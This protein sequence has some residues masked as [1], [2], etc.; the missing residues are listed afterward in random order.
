M[1]ITTPNLLVLEVITNFKDIYADTT[2]ENANNGNLRPET[3][4]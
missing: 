4:I 2:S 3:V 1:V